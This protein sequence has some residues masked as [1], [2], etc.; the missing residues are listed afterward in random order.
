MKETCDAILERMERARENARSTRNMQEKKYNC[1]LCKDTEFIFVE[2]ENGNEVAKRCKC[3]EKNMSIR[4]LKNSGISEEDAK[5]GITDFKTFGENALID[6]R[7]KVMKY[8]H[9]FESIRDERNNSL[10]LSGAS[11]RGKTTLGMSVANNLIGRC[12][13]VRYMPYRDE[14]TQLK[15]ELVSK[16]ELKY[17]EHM[18]RLKNAKVLFMDDMLKGKTTESDL[19]ILYEIVNTRYLAKRPMIVST[20]KTLEEIID[21]DEAIGSR[22]AEMAQGYI[23]TFDKSIPNYRT[24]GLNLDVV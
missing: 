9:D 1:P 19:N 10:L 22:L 24:R 16:D 8:I 23:V 6:A 4:L 14:F 18:Y 7:N 12:I 2:D 5:K 17:S 3:F 13:G 15:R 20:E 11:G 21:F